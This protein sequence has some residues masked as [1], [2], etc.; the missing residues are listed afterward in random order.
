MTTARP[1]YEDVTLAAGPVPV[2]LRPTLRAAATLE[3]EAGGLP[4]LLDA[5][6]GFR[7]GTIK[8]VIRASATDEAAAERLLD[9]YRD[10]PLAPFRDN[11]LPA[12]LELV[13]GFVP[14]TGDTSTKGTAKNTTTAKPRP[15]AEAYADLYGFATGW[16]GWSPAE[17]WNATPTEIARAFAAHLDKLRAVH[18]SGDDDADRHEKASQRAENEALGLDPEFDRRGLQKLKARL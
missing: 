9:S 16:L 18:G 14:D 12:V 7:L 17:A 11:V 6:D 3:R 1:A 10:R 2:R 15:W 4:A 5:L 8:G 13:A